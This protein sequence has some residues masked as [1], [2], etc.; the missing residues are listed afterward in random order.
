MLSNSMAAALP[1]DGV[2]DRPRPASQSGAAAGSRSRLAPLV[3]T[4]GLFYAVPP[5]GRSATSSLVVRQLLA[6]EVFSPAWLSVGVLMWLGALASA[7]GA[8]LMWANLFTFALVLDAATVTAMTEGVATLAAAAFS[9]LL[10]AWARRAAGRHRAPLAF[11]LLV[12]AGASV[13]VPVAGRASKKLRR[14][15]SDH[16]GGK[17]PHTMSTLIAPR[18]RQS[19]RWADHK[20]TGEKKSSISPT[21]GKRECTAAAA[22][23]K[24]ARHRLSGVES[25]SGSTTIAS[26]HHR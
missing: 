19:A 9:F 8:A 22:T 17:P 12:I 3:A 20:P 5:D 4:V 1:R 26:A 24:T 14:G 16:A 25:G 21:D 7:A 13:A 2:R 10:L 11:L 23:A 18:C 15:R 6:R